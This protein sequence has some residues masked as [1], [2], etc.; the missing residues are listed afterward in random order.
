MTPDQRKTTLLDILN[1]SLEHM[2]PE[3][4]IRN[5]ITF[6]KESNLLTIAGETVAL[7]DLQKIWVTGV[8][9]AAVR[10]AQAVTE[11]VGDRIA[12]GLIIAPDKPEKKISGIQVL[13]GS[14]PIPDKESLSSTYELLHFAQMI[15]AEAPVI[16][17]LSGGASALF[18][19][20]ED[21]LEINEIGQ[22]HKLLL[23][24]GMDIHQM[25]TIRK[26]VSKVKAG[27]LL[28][29]LSHTQL[30]DLVISDVPG[31]QL[32][33]IGSGPTTFEQKHYDEA[34]RMMKQ[35]GIWNHA[36]HSIRAYIARGMHEKL[37]QEPPVPFRHHPKIVSSAEMLAETVA[38][39]AKKNDLDTLV[40]SPAYNNPIEEVEKQ[41]LNKIQAV[42]KK[43]I[44]HSSDGFSAPAKARQQNQKNQKQYQCLIFYGESYVNV[45]GNG[46]GGR[47]Q[48]LALRIARHLNPELPVTLASLGTDGIDGPTDAAGA[49]VDE[50]TAVRAKEMNLDPD[51]YLKK[52]DSYTFFEKAGGHIKTGPT[53]NNLMDL[54]VILMP[55]HDDQD[56][57]S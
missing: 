57:T 10:M 22:L 8:G 15:P 14:H 34:F 21:E 55:N 26:C 25:N 49:V 17:L 40:I 16:F 30:F 53:G 4:V 54:Q 19:L 43:R 36:P 9:K 48:E 45:T 18:C 7:N 35:F 56:N 6:E 1:D 50:T 28:R 47:N 42:Y 46:K 38:A 27:G 51:A 13:K 37:N 31:D 33:S 5:S 52:N 32:A 39:E 24:S 23:D 44:Q 12:D 11:I 41:I 2:R 3:N 20:P 29:A